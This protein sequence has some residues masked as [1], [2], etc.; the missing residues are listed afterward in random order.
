[1][2]TKEPEPS[3]GEQAPAGMLGGE[4]RQW[5]G[6]GPWGG[7]EAS[8]SICTACPQLHLPPLDEAPRSKRV[9]KGEA[10][11]NRGE[12]PW[13]CNKKAPLAS[14]NGEKQQQKRPG[15]A[16][17]GC[18]IARASGSHGKP[19]GAAGLQRECQTALIFT[20]L[21]YSLSSVL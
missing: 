5:E 9:W 2:E 10:T 3:W 16:G 14:S 8:L 4:Q 15:G 17:G 6:G 18:P 19:R 21:F 12:S 11:M 1:M 13:F 20:N 7:A